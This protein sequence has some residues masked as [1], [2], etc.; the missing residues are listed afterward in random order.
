MMNVRGTLY[1]PSVHTSY[2]H[3]IFYWIIVY[4]NSLLFQN[5]Q[6]EMIL[7]RKFLVWM[8][9]IYPI[10]VPLPSDGILPSS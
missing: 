5:H 2:Y 8:F 7:N 1:G 3:L 4:D 10:A 9:A 6:L